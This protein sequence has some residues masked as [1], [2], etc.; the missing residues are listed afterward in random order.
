MIAAKGYQWDE[1]NDIAIQCFNNREIEVY[2][3]SP[4][5]HDVEWFID[6][7]CTKEERK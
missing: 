4:M 2:L 7:V 3:K 5:I 6:K 1:A